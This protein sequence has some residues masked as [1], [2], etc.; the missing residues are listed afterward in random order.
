MT[1]D[2]LAQCVGDDAALHLMARKGGLRVYVPK[3]VTPALVA[4]V[5]CE[6]AA[7]RLSESYGGLFLV[8]PVAKRWRMRR[9]KDR[10]WSAQQIALALGMTEQAVFRGLSETPRQHEQV[11]MRDGKRAA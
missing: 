8:L 4:I 9:L 7:G 3:Q 5:G 11:A 1:A 2:D 10:G 6:R